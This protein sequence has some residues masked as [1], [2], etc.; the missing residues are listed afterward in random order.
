ML[1]VLQF[2][3]LTK[4]TA[5]LLT[6]DIDMGFLSSRACLSVTLQYCA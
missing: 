5:P 2:Y 1:F 6:N 4:L 3:T